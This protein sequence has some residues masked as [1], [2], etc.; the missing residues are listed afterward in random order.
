MQHKTL[1]IAGMHRSGT[2]L[3]TQWLHRCG[4]NVG[5]K[6]LGSG[7]GNEDGHYEDLEF[8]NF[9]VNALRNKKLHDSGIID[10]P[11]TPLSIPEKEELQQIV[12]R[13]NETYGEWGW[14]D[15]RTCLFLKEYQEIIPDAYYLVVFRDWKS[16]VSSLISRTYK[17]EYKDDVI[18]KKGLFKKFRIQRTIQKRIRKLCEDHAAH[19]LK[20]WIFYNQEILKSLAKTTKENYTIINF[21][22]LL[23]SDKAVFTRLSNY[24]RFK[25]DYVS[26]KDIYKPGLLSKEINVGKFVDQNLINQAV[27]MQELLEQKASGDFLSTLSKPA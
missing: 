7:I 23:K 12:S 22:L 17:V 1:I 16:T 4:L 26:F 5:E 9:Q 27:K 21:G 18:V 11:V 24:W 2:S 20:V 15:P 14:K 19:F 10:H 6:L 13:K 8:Y 25:L 3:I